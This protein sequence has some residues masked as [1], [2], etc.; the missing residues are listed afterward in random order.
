MAALPLISDAGQAGF[1]CLQRVGYAPLFISL[2]EAFRRLL[3]EA[4]GQGQTGFHARYSQ[5]FNLLQG[6][7]ELA[8]F[9]C[10]LLRASSGFP[11]RA[12]ALLAGA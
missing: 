2:R 5:V 12:N 10:E 1:V 8:A 9:G 11:G 3:N 7:H 6:L 4:G